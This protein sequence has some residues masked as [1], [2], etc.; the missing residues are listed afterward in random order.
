MI[1]TQVDRTP[2]F[3]T[4]ITF[5]EYFTGAPTT[6][7]ANNQCPKGFQCHAKFCRPL[8][9]SDDACLANELC[10]DNV[11]QEIC[12]SDT[13]CQTTEICQG[14]KCIPGCRSNSDCPLEHA[15]D[16]NQCIDPCTIAQCGVNAICVTQ[17]HKPFCTCPPGKFYF[18]FWL[19]V[20]NLDFLVW[21]K[22]VF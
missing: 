12:K 8:C 4:F 19:L 14:V 9:N 11:C 6:C 3:L 5:I 13:D 7:V 18:K 22:S 17:N 15:C 21:S 2:I 10:I 16:N 20:S 1:V